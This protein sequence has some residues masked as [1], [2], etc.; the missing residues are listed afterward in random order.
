MEAVAQISLLV[1][2]VLMVAGGI[3]GFVKAESKK[4]LVA[5]LLSAILLL[6]ARLI[7]SITPAAGYWMGVAIVGALCIV[8][9][10]R[11]IKTRAFVPSGIFLLLCLLEEGLLLPV[12]LKSGN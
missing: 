12:A 1:F 6:G 9:L 11:L 7:T 3:Y 5:G 4:S 8:F 2:A 10:V